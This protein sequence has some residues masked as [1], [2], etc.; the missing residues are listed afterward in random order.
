MH[1]LTTV[2]ER[3]GDLLPRTLASLRAGGFDKPHLFVDC[4]SDSASWKREFGLE[5][6]ARSERV[7]T[8]GNWVLALYE[9]YYLDPGADRY[10]VTQDDLV[11][12]RNLRSYLERVPYPEKGYENLYTFRANETM[13]VGKPVGW[14]LG[15]PLNSGPEGFQ[16]GLG[17]VALVFSKEAV[18]TLLKAEHLVDRPQDTGRGWK[19]IDG[20]IV[21]AMNKA[22]WHEWI[23]SPSLVQHTGDVSSMGNRPHALAESFRGEDFDALSLLS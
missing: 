13:I 17:A 1:G 8:A 7:R 20:G 9:L 3:R 15:Y 22:G 23:H 6:T 14:H 19:A 5:V 10:L 12:C 21:T 16:K 11:T 18:I 4:D 2:Q